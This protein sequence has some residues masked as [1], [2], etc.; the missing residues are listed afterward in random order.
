MY[1][2]RSIGLHRGVLCR[3][4]RRVRACPGG[5]GVPSHPHWNTGVA[6]LWANLLRAGGAARPLQ[7]SPVTH[8]CITVMP[9]RLLL[10]LWMQ[11]QGSGWHALLIWNRPPLSRPK[12]CRWALHRLP[13]GALVCCSPRRTKPLSPKTLCQH[14]RQPLPS[15]CKFAR[16]H[17]PARSMVRL[18]G[19]VGR[20][21]GLQGPTPGGPTP[22]T[23]S[24]HQPRHPDAALAGPRLQMSK[25]TPP[26]CYRGQREAHPLTPTGQIEGRRPHWPSTPLVGRSHR[27]HCGLRGRH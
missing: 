26:C 6:N 18:G 4:A 3:S 9:P 21:R 14:P 12:L 11:G 13:L 27:S 7:W 19:A 17:S 22:H 20:R 8:T 16:P 2:V 23:A 24:Q 5:G 25:S 10:L 15:L 1:T